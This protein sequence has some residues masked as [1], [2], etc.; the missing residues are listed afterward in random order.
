MI[1]SQVQQQALG[2]APE[3]DVEVIRSEFAANAIPV[4]VGVTMQVLVTLTPPQR[5][6]RHH[7]EVIGVGADDMDRGGSANP[8]MGLSE[9]FASMG[10]GNRLPRSRS[11]EKTP[12]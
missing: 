8:D 12:P 10:D 2:D 6:H 5:L 11:N 1:D 9:I 3:L 7:P 4:V